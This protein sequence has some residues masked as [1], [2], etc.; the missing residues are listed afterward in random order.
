MSFTFSHAQTG[1]Q[2]QDIFLQQALKKSGATGK[3]VFFMGFTTWCP[4]CKKMKESVFTDSGVANYYNAHFICVMQDMESGEGPTL[5]K[6]FGVQSYPTFVFLDSTGQRLFQVAGELDVSTMMLMAHDAQTPAKQMPYLQ[7]QFE[8]N[9]ADTAAAIPYLQS[10]TRARLPTQAVA[11]SFFETKKENELMNYPSW[12]VLNMGVS[13]ISSPEF[14][15]IIDHQKQY[16]EIV[17]PQRV[18]RKIYRTTAYNLQQPADK[19]DT[20]EYFR[21]RTI[22]ST[23]H[24]T[25][26]D[27]LVFNYDLQLYDLNN[28]WSRYEATALKGTFTYEWN[29]YSQ[30]KHIADIFFKRVT[31]PPSLKEATKWAERSTELKP[32]YGNT[33]LYAQLLDKTGE[34]NESKK[35]AQDA[36]D[37]ASKTNSNHTEA[38]QILQR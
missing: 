4:H 5:S 23:F 15:F 8:K 2:F 12:R 34:K 31:N 7:K 37:I 35:V 24:N 10:L 3:I 9:P 30:L 32:E 27:S 22:A 18:Q 26:V 6:R 25:Q 16:G 14:Q 1:I 38:D 28:Q 21:L 33:L 19:N 13:D 17:S 29:D 20:T 36:I 11:N